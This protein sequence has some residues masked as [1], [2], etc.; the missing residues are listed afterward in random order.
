VLPRERFVQ[1]ERGKNQD[2]HDAQLV[3]RYSRG[4]A[5]LQSLEV[6]EPGKTRLPV[7]TMPGKAM[8]SARF[9]LAR[10]VSL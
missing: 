6:T 4:F 8:S 7:L 9:C 5:Y 3:H 2:E 10:T 1:K